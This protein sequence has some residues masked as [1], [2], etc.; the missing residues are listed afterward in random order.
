MPEPSAKAAIAQSLFE[1]LPQYDHETPIRISGKP[2]QQKS[3]LLRMLSRI[4]VGNNG[5]GQLGQKIA[6][7]RQ[8]GV[9]DPECWADRDRILL[10]VNS[11]KQ[12]RWVVDEMRRCWSS[13][14]QAI[15]YLIPD[16]AE[17]NQDEAFELT[18]GAL[19]RTDIETFGQTDGKILVAPMNAIER[20]FNILNV[21]GKAAFGGVY[22]LTRPYP[23]PHDTQAIAQELNRRA[24]DWV[25]NSG[26]TAWKEDGIQGRAEA[27][28]QR[29]SKYWR[30]AE[31][32]SYY[33]TLGDDPELG[34]FP[35]RDLASTTA[36][37]I[38]QAVGRLLRGGVP[39]QAFFVDAAWSPNYAREKVTETPRTSLLA[40]IIDVLE[41]YADQDQIG[42]ALYKPLTDAIASIQD[43][44][45]QWTIDPRDRTTP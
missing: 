21:N 23:H 24:L 32:R 9:Q 5:R 15:R 25:N 11:Y 42:N 14:S 12:S 2:E 7:L 3:T 41:D 8:L 44:K 38:L 19:R 13:M 4:L 45:F 26:F 34:A 22:F 31:Y 43:E 10:L 40:A 29:A 16:R 6:E 36:G 27:V 17:D 28:R 20:G 37:I 39:F 33:S 1:F 18:S 30:L 35:R